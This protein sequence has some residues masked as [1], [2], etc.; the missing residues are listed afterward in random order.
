MHISLGSYIK[1]E[2]NQLT[3]GRLVKDYMTTRMVT[4]NEDRSIS[5]IAT[6]M[7]NK[8][9][10][11]V[12][13][14]DERE[15]ISGILTER[16]IVRAVS[17]GSTLNNTPASAIKWPSLISISDDAHIEDAAKLMVVNGIRHLLVS[18]RLTQHIVG[19]ITVTDLAKYLKGT[20][21]DDEI[22]ASEVW[23][24]FF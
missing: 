5:D 7:L 21:G 22:V 16:D 9:I 3:R 4:V 13:L 19:I 15:R 20:F 12:A 14:T 6:M 10:S 24:L 11:S 1:H 23:Q 18:E 8:N 2:M 17:N